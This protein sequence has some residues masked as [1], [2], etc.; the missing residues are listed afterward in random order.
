[1]KLHI[2]SYGTN[3]CIQFETPFSLTTLARL[4]EKGLLPGRQRRS[5]SRHTR[6]FGV[7]RQILRSVKGA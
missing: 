4:R 5:Y 2:S 6:T 3:Y 7:I 1:M